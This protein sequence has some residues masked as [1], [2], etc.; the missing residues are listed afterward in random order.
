MNASLIACSEVLRLLGTSA[1]IKSATPQEFAP[2]LAP[3]VDSRE[4][5]AGQLG[6]WALIQKIQIKCPAECLASGIVLVDLPGVVDSN[7]ARAEIANKYMKEADHFWITAPITRAVN[8]RVAQG[9]PHHVCLCWRLTHS[10]SDR[11]S[12]RRFLHPGPAWY[13][14]IMLLRVLD[15]YS[16]YCI[17][18][19]WKVCI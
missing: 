13:V 5:H 16:R 18:G 17:T 4:Q 19:R 3:Y 15:V 7:A 1:A 8:D 14:F 10:M 11:A 6:Y 9:E 2:L 12:R